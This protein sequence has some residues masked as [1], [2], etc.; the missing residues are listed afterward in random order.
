MKKFLLFLAV[1]AL[2]GLIAAGALWW[3]SRTSNPPGYKAIDSIPAPAGFVRD[4][5]APG[6]EGAFLGSLPLRPRGTRVM[7][8]TGGEA[9]FQWLSWAVVDMPLLSN[10]EQ[11][12]DMTMRLRAEWLFAQ[13]RYSDIRFRDV[14]GNTLRYNGS[15]SRPALER[16]LSR[17]YGV[18]STFS[19][20]RETE[21]RDIAAVRPG[22]VLVYPARG[23]ERLGHA[24]LVAAVATNRSTGQKAVMCVEGNTPARDCHV[25]RN[26]LQPWRGPWFVLDPTDSSLQISVFHFSRDELRHY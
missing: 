19:V 13:G 22:D 14:N 8:Y 3:Y 18:C 10:A 7:L 24:V 5:V 17:A 1:L 23:A 21:P 6:S 9:R 11:C 4:S 25:I 26:I 20:S 12:A 15:G 2:L 16:F